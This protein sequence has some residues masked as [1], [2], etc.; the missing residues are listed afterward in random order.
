MDREQNNEH[1]NRTVVFWIFDRYEH[2][3]RNFM[4]Q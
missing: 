4:S 2:G 3:N 1:A